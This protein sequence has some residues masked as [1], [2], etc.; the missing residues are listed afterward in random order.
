[1]IADETSLTRERPVSGGGGD[2]KTPKPAQPPLTRLQERAPGAAIEDWFKPFRNS[3]EGSP[4]P[5]I[6]DIV[7][8]FNDIAAA[9]NLSNDPSQVARA[10]IALKEQVA[11]LRNNA[12]RLPPPFSD[13]LR[14]AIREF[15]D[16]MASSTAGQLQ[17]ALRNEVYPACQEAVANRYPFAK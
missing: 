10:N 8:N 5:P 12:A 17:L 16:G 11:K 14:A 3:V 13:F 6:D 2:A 4:R 9:L 7:A 1:S 15:E